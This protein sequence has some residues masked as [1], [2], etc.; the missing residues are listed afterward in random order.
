VTT[1]VFNH[2]GSIDKFLGDG[3]LALFGAPLS[4]PNH[5]LDAVRAAQEIRAGLDTLNQTRRQAGQVPIVIGTAVATGLAVTGNIGSEKQLSFTVTGD[6]VNLGSR[7]VGVAEAGQT[8][9]TTRTYEL[10]QRDAVTG[11]VTGP[12]RVRGPQTIPV[13]GRD[14]PATIYILEAE[15]VPQSLGVAQPVLAREG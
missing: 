9:I 5:A 13:R 15:A 6:T 12:W 1:A 8:L 2:H 3:V 14:E 10:M 7:L 11:A 4:D